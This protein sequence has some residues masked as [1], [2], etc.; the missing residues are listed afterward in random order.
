MRLGGGG[1]IAVGLAGA[2]G[3][4]VAAV[5]L[6]VIVVGVVVVRVPGVVAGQ[7]GRVH[8]PG[9]VRQPL[10]HD[11][12]EP[13]PPDDQEGDEARDGDGAAQHGGS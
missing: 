7:R 5:D 2:L 9:P 12:S 3:P 1:S 10:V 13:G 6:P 8:G 4:M 11:A